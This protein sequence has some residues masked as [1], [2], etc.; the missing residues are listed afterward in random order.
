MKFLLVIDHP[1]QNSFNSQVMHNFVEGIQIKKHSFEICDLEKDQ[2]DPIMT[3]KDLEKYA[4]GGF[5]NEKIKT[6]QR[7]ILSADHLVF[8]FPIWWVAP[9]ARLKGWF[10]KVL[11]PKFAFSEGQIPAPLLR[12]IQKTII[13]TTTG[14]GDEAFQTEFGRAFI[15]VIG[16]GILQ[17]CGIQDVE[18]FNCGD[19]GFMS[20]EKHTE[21]LAFVRSYAEKL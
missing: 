8:F 13:F 2:F 1:N 18:W 11:L 21:W 3:I 20:R 6:Y 7:Q 14:V 16:K 17:F 15:E 19:V 10:D 4:A 12:H 9:P 5:T